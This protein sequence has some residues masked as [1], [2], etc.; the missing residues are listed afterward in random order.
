MLL[1]KRLDRVAWLAAAPAR[2]PQQPARVLGCAR[3][4]RPHERHVRPRLHGRARG[5]ELAA[6]ERRRLAH[7][8]PLRRARKDL[9]RGLRGLDRRSGCC[10]CVERTAIG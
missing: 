3:V 7:K 6:R 2:L 1:A 5:R 8:R 9:R 4:A 10:H